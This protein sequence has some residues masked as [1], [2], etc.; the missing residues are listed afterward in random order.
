MSQTIE[1]TGVVERVE[2]RKATVRILQASACS[3]CQAAKLCRSSES[4]EKLVDVW[5][6]PSQHF[7]AG[8]SV[9]I[10]G[11]TSQSLWAVLWAYALPLLILLVALFGFSSVLQNEGLAAL[12]S[13]LLLLPYFF[14]LY[15][16][17]DRISRKLSFKIKN[18]T[19]V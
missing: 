14:M 5:L 7:A 9:E 2:G 17:R 19:N 10:V 16:F 11:T 4:R 8:Q 1:H 15:V 18:S 6:Q 3:A 13:L 12:L